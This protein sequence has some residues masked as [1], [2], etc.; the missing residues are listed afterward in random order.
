M[1][2]VEELTAL[3]EILNRC[4]VSKGEGLWLQAFIEKLTPQ[5]VSVPEAVAPTPAIIEQPSESA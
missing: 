1:V 5:P 2:T 3:V 4:P